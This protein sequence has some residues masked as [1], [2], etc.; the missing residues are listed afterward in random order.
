[1]GDVILANLLEKLTNNQVFSRVFNEKPN[2]RE[3]FWHLHITF[4]LVAQRLKRLP[5]MWE[6]WV[7]SLGWEDP[8]EKEKATHSTILA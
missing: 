4:P 8:L 3:L 7:Q 1:M 5:A 6:T 2:L